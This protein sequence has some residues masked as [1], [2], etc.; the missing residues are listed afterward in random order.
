MPRYAA[1]L[2]GVSPSNARMP[3]LRRAFEAAGFEDVATVRSSGNVLFTARA[4]PGPALE[5][6]AEAAL[7]AGLGRAFPV[8]V[9]EVA[10]LRRL[11]ASDPYGGLAPPGAKRVVTFLRGAPPAG[12]ALPIERDGAAIVALLGRE[13]F[14]A[15]RPSPRGPV[16]M[17]LLE[18]TFGKDVTTRTWETVAL[19]A[20]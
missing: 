16:F 15:Y 2:R 18:R 7:R 8:I 14:T 3:E 11:V 9:R 5:R 6:R 17:A 12:L 1:L 13:A 4:A 19:L 20:R 10:S